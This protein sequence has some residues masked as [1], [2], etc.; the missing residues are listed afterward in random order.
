MR[1]LQAIGPLRNRAGGANE[2]P[3]EAAGLPDKVS[4]DSATLATNSISAAPLRVR[5]RL[6]EMAK[7]QRYVSDELTHFVGRG[8]EPASQYELLIRILTSGWL[9]HPPHTPN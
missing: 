8:R 7:V 3:W 2:E 4:L 1:D 5:R 6:H 9:T